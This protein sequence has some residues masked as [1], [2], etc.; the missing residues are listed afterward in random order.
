MIKEKIYKAV[1]DCS[2]QIIVGDN[3]LKKRMQSAKNYI[4]N[5]DLS[6]WAFSKLVAT[7]S[8]DVCYGSEAKPFFK[9]HDFI[10]VLSLRD[11]SLKD[12]VIKKFLSWSDEVDY[13][14][15]RQKFNLDQ[16]NLKR[17]ELLIHTN[18][19]SLKIRDKENFSSKN[20]DLFL[21]GFRTEIRIEN[22]YRNQKLVKDAKIEHGTNCFVCSF[23][24]EKK[25]G[26]R[27]KGFIEIHHLI[28]I[29]N[30][31]RKTTVDDVVPVCSNCHRMLHKGKF[32]ISI[33]E[34]KR[35]IE[36]TKSHS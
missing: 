11:D 33:E 23:S 34:L 15:I 14:D 17:F 19:I 22:A 31:Q 35:I 20:Q 3:G 32:P 1:E 28:P 12:S 18:L 21:E 9:S 4:A 25:Y 26:V 16:E 2:K 36:E 13:F 7:E 24:F 10:N 29:K 30:G 27:G 8:F 5:E 6:Q